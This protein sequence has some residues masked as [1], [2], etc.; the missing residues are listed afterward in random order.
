MTQTSTPFL[1]DWAS[2]PGDTLADLLDEH[3]MTQTE[4]AERLG[5]SLKHV[6]R[7]IKGAASISAD[8]ALGLEKVFGASASFWMTREA[9]YQADKA[10][11]GQRQEFAKS[12]GWAKQFP[13]AELR[14]RGLIARTSD[15]PELVE[16]LLAFLGIAHPAQWRDPEVVYR[17]S[18]KFE[19]NPFAL[20]AWLR[21]G[22]QQAADVACLPYDENRFLE[23]LEDARSLTRLGPEKWWP[24]LQTRCATAGVAVVIVDTYAGAKTNGAT[25]WISPDKALIQLSLRY[26]WEDIFWFSFFH[27]A[28]HVVLHRKKDLFVEVAPQDQASDP[29]S[30]RLE[31]EANRFAAR[32]LIPSVHDRRLRNLTVA[33]VTAFAD[34]LDIAPAIVVGRM[35]HEGLLPWNQGNRHRRRLKFAD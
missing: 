25:H 28:G 15:G 22:E 2:P 17:K 23:V 1:P 13:I 8:L 6:N 35:H 31:D 11:Q 24:E 14:N 7:V 5:V 30:Q 21:E 18:Q 26:S 9:Q 20:S 19:S 33:Q 16:Q 29:E 34:S 32:T 27:E 3:S 4:L 10:R 12:V